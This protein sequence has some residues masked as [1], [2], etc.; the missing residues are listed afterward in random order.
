MYSASRGTLRPVQRRHAEP[1]GACLV[2]VSV[3]LKLSQD[4]AQYQPASFSK[5]RMGMSVYL[6]CTNLLQERKYSSFWYNF[7]SSYLAPHT[8]GLECFQP[9]PYMVSTA[10]YACHNRKILIS[11]LAA[12]RKFFTPSTA[13]KAPAF[14]TSCL[15]VCSQDRRIRR[16]GHKWYSVW[17]HHGSKKEEVWGIIVWMRIQRILVIRYNSQNTLS[18]L[19]ET[20]TLFWKAE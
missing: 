19:S 3:A 9:L 17:R 13:Q 2:W 20:W 12:T 18:H 6:Y 11:F 5:A 1:T 15:S 14:L 4:G 16:L 7:C 8:S 10:A